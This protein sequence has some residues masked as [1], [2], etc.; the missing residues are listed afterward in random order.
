[1]SRLNCHNQMYGQHYGS[2]KIYKV[3]KLPTFEAIKC[4]KIIVYQDLKH[5][6]TRFCGSRLFLLFALKASIRLQKLYRLPPGLNITK[7]G[8][9]ERLNT[10][11]KG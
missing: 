3:K 2:S 4:I 7:Y 8:L 9:L 6:F 1:M 11:A 10:Q 5:T